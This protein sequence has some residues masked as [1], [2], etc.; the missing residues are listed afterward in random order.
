[1]TL[2][3]GI[4]IGGAIGAII[5]IEV[6]ERIIFKKSEQLSRSTRAEFLKLFFGV[7]I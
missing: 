3:A 6:L 2:L 4:L 1:M 7:E 5:T